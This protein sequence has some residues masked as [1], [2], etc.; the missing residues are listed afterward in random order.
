MPPHMTFLHVAHDWKI[1][2]PADRI[3][4]LY[5]HNLIFCS[6]TFLGGVLE[7]NFGDSPGRSYDEIAAWLFRIFDIHVS[8]KLDALSVLLLFASAFGIS[9]DWESG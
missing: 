3:C 5:I 6:A 2:R 8:A 9:R 7:R 4:A 1:M